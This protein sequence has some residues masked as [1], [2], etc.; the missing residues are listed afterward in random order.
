[1]K[2]SVIKESKKESN[3]LKRHVR[4]KLNKM[5]PN[6]RAIQNFEFCIL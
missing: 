6:E 1:M 5:M 3:V 2:K 4:N